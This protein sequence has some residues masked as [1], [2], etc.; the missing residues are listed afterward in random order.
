MSSN[1][2]LDSPAM[3]LLRRGE[4]TLDVWLANGATRAEIEAR[5]RHR[6]AALLSFSRRQ[7]RFYKRHYADVPECSTDLTQ[8]PPVTKPM[9]MEHFDDVVTDTGITKDDIAAFV[10]DESKIGHR[11]IGRYP[12]WTT[13]GTTGEPGVFVQDE[14]AWTVADVAADRWILPAM[15]RCIPLNRL[16]RQNLRVAIVAVSGGHFGGAAGLELKRRESV[17]GARRFRLFSAMRP[18]DDLIVDLNQYRPAILGGYSSVLVEL[19]R[20]QRDGRLDISPAVVTPTAEPISAAQ[21]RDLRRSFDCV[22][23]ELYGATECFPIAVECE[24]GTLH[25]NIDW[26]VLEPV[27]EDYQPVEPGTPSDTV[28]ITSLSNRVQPL[29]RYDLGDSITLTGERCPCGSEFPVLAV[30]GRQGDVLWFETDEGNEVPIFPLALSSV[31]EEI[32]GV[33]RTQIIRTAPLA[34]QVRVD[35]TPDADEGD[36]WTNVEQ[37]L[38]SFLRT[39]GVSSVAVEAASESPQ[40]EP[41]SA[42]FRHVWSEVAE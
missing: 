34:L 32:P 35:V 18:L 19:A 9:L 6:L 21:K 40:R 33:R 12:V 3:S 7:S 24:R 41:R 15:V 14:T 11:Y 30:E 42:K 23:R 1:D 4:I 16:V 26:V 37:N 27:N 36:V 10:A 39:H 8:F 31:V 17:S 25:A 22:V 29:I 2:W 20:A 28:L 38:Q 13:S 5:Q